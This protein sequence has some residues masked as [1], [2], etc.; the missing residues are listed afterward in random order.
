M[1]F[2][3]TCSVCEPVLSTCTSTCIQEPTEAMGEVRSPAIRVTGAWAAVWELEPTFNSR[4]AT[5]LSIQP[6]YSLMPTMPLSFYPVSISRLLWASV[7][8]LYL[9]CVYVYTCSH[10]C[11]LMCRV[12]YVC[13]DV[14]TCMHVYAYGMWVWANVCACVHACVCVHVCVCVQV[15]D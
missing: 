11:M 5:A 3:F 15:R 12:T 14:G 8:C 10:E 13:M 1:S 2:K 7:S 4:T 9:L 6:L